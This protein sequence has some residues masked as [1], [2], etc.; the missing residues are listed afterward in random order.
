MNRT[1]LTLVSLGLIAAAGGTAVEAQAQDTAYVEVAPIAVEPVRSTQFEAYLV[2]GF[3][4]SVSLSQ[5]G[6]GSGDADLDP[7]VGLGLRLDLPLG[8]MITLGPIA[9]LHSYQTDGATGRDLALDAGLVLRVGHVFNAGGMD[10]DVYGAVPA[11]F[12]VYFP[13]D[14]FDSDN[15]IGFNVGLFGGAQLFVTR[16]VGIMAEM[17]WQL[18]NVYNDESTLTANQFRMNVGAV[19]RL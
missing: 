19:L 13:D 14:D 5:D 16:R 12:T 11:G 6:F 1:S 8:D 7:T 2:T 18:H 4:G 17:G 3:G 9:E 15:F 10:L